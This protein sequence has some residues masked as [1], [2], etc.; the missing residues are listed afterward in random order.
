MNVLEK[1]LQKVRPKGQ[2]PVKIVSHLVLAD[3]TIKIS[4]ELADIMAGEE[5][6]VVK[7]VRFVNLEILQ[8]KLTERY[9]ESD[10]L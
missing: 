6:L 2:E 10:I 9:G 3:G 1:L 7:G 5:I 8:A 4:N